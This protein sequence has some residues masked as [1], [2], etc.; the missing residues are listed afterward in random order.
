MSKE[1][2]PNGVKSSRLNVPLVS[3]ILS[4]VVIL[5]LSSCSPNY[6]SSAHST[7]LY[8]RV[9]RS[10]KLRCAYMVYPPVCIKDPSTGKLSGIAIDALELI[11]KKLGISIVWVEEVGPGTMIEGLQ[12][13][14]YDMIASTFWT[15]A[16]RAKVIL[17]SKPLFFTPIF[18][19]ARHGDK[20][21]LNHISAI[22]SKDVTIATVDGGTAQVIAESDFPRAKTL[23]LPELSDFTQD[24]LNIIT[25]KA[26]VTFAEPALVNRFCQK[27]PGTIDNVSPKQP[28]RVFQNCWIFKRGEY[29]FKSM[30]DTVLEELLNSGEVDKVL[31]RY[32]TAPGEIYRDRAPYQVH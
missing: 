4:T 23:S 30:F 10:G 16:A 13:N 14:R 8:D 27:N 1:V 3:L 22:N 6:T 28:L 11:A 25:K 2:G 29:E 7:S 19:F 26:D 17:F 18:V 24:L 20:R 15:N 32:E 31:A 9:L 5:G 21:F 12:S